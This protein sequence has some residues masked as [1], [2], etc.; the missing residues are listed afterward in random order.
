MTK[1]LPW[2]HAHWPWIV[3]SLVP[4]LI[5]ILNAA[6]KRF[7]EYPKAVRWLM[8]IVDVL[9]LTRAKNTPDGEI[10]GKVKV[11]LF[12]LSKPTELYGPVVPAAV[13]DE[14]KSAEE[15]TKPGAADG[16]VAIGLLVL[17][18]LVLSALLFA[19]C[20]AV[21]KSL[22]KIQTGTAALRQEGTT[23]FDGQCMAIA[24]QCPKGPANACAPWVKCKDQ[25][26]G[27]YAGT[28]GIQLLIA[29]GL[30]LIGIK[31][32][33]GA[34]A[35]LSKVSGAVTELARKLQEMKVLDAAVNSVYTFGRMN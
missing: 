24:V 5:L 16:F 8:F 6:T 15:A 19:G 31:D 11:P 22:I 32:E 1:V 13:T 3:G 34:A 26:A 14:K 27:F 2:L 23:F 21:E 29:T 20:G 17:V 30:N 25:R 4:V 12:Q 33:K 28:N 18:A 10:L 9:S 7:S 35:I